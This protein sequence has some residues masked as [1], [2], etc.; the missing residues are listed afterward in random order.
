MQDEV[1]PEADLS[2]EEAEIDLKEVF[3]AI[4]KRWYIVILSLVVGAGIGFF[5]GGMI[6]HTVYKSEAVYV[7][8]YSGGTSIGEV[9]SE[10][11]YTTK[12]L[13][14]CVTIVEQNKFLNRI[15]AEL[16]KSSAEYGY[17]DEKTLSEYI[18]YTYNASENTSL[19]VSVETESAALSY[20]IISVIAGEYNSDGEN[21]TLL[22]GYIKEN[23]NLAGV[24]SLQFSL[25]NELKEAT[26]PE[27]D[28]TRLMATV[29]GG[30]AGIAISA[31]SVCCADMMDKRVKNEGDFARAY[32]DF[33]VLGVIP[34]FY[35]KELAKSRYY[36]SYSAK[37]ASKKNLNKVESDGQIGK[38][39]A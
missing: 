2:D 32:K 35:D 29:I 10:Y 1:N 4:I 6:K 30:A 9:T 17:I 12:I 7:V 28:S 3:S 23:Y 16:N 22:A 5:V 8:S 19:T 25:I 15:M 34:D 37:D 27:K 26:E 14:N 20:R 18:T 13:S 36:S 21:T 11:T 33:P 31:V 24:S 38:E 39:Q